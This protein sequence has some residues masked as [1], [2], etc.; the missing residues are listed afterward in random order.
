MKPALLSTLALAL[1][2]AAASA[3]AHL[4]LF[5]GTFAAEVTGAT[6]TGSLLME[7][8]SDG[9]TLAINASWSGL[10][11][12]T[13]TSHIHCC[14]AVPN[15]GTAG[16]ALAEGG[17]LPGFP[18]GVSSGSYVRV[19][20]LSQTNQYGG[21]FLTASGGTA[22]GAEARLI[23]NLTSGQA[24]FN[25]HSSTFAGGEIRAFVTV[26]PEPQTWALM[27]GGLA[28]VSL[29]ARRRSI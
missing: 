24:Y 13:T 9:R 17:I 12:I 23:S 2:A 8:D 7:Y 19:I 1:A 25:I 29:L 11:G 26:V 28:A 4:T 27:F 18:L 5:T 22:A 16:V 3:Q 15:T 6:G 21:G 10:S 14:T 20:D